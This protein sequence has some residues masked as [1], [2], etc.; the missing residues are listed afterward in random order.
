VLGPGGAVLAS[1]AIPSSTQVVRFDGAIELAASKD[2]YAIVRVDGDRPMSPN[3]GDS[4]SFLVYPVAVTNPIWIDAN[5]DGR[6]QPRAPY[7][8]LE[9]P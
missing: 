3:V 8:Q 7:P 9:Q 5:A 2:G 1:R 4:A 6:I